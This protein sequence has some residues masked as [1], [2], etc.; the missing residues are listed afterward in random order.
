[1]TEVSRH[2][3]LMH[4]FAH[5]RAY[6]RHPSIRN[7]HTVRPPA[8]NGPVPGPVPPVASSFLRTEEHARVLIKN[9]LSVAGTGRDH[10][11]GG[12]SQHDLQEL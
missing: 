12:A 2:T 8:S 10:T 3:W 6:G 1:M 5:L 4:F 11:A 9:S 7:H